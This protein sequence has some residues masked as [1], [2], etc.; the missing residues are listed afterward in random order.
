MHDFVQT[1]RKIIQSNKMR[2][3]NQANKM[4]NKVHN[5]CLVSS[6][7]SRCVTLALENHIG[8]PSF[9]QIIKVFSKL[10]LKTYG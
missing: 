1:K 4:N 8:S 6:G 2:K 5:V 7:F 10:L 3:I 9:W